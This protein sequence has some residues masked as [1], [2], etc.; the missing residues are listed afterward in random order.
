MNRFRDP[1]RTELHVI[2]ELAPLHLALDESL[3]LPQAL[4]HAGSRD[5]GG[6]RNGRIAA[7]S[8]SA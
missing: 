7:A 6:R 3:H 8:I 1:A 4:E 5:S 2:G